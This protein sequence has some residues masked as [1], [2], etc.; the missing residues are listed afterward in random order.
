MCFIEIDQ[1]CL[2]VSCYIFPLCIS[3]VKHPNQKLFEYFQL[4]FCFLSGILIL[5]HGIF[6]GKFSKVSKNA[7]INKI[8]PLWFLCFFCVV[9]YSQKFKVEND[10]NIIGQ[11]L[12]LLQK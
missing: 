1:K 7:K 12:L 11:A 9:I 8:F 10:E 6:A 5:S 2:S 4:S 3:D